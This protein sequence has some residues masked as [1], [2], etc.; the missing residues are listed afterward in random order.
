[1][2]ISLILYR[3]NVPIADYFIPFY[4]SYLM[5]EVTGWFC[6]ADQSLETAIKRGVNGAGD[7]Q[8]VEHFE[9]CLVELEEARQR[10]KSLEDGGG[11]YKN[12]GDLFRKAG[13]RSALELACSALWRDRQ[14]TKLS[15]VR[16]AL[17]P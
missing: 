15:K 4:Q 8:R 14:V 17:V 12:G 7:Q 10:V 6:K 11:G 9:A 2:F 3:S 13:A 5:K 1:M 16:F